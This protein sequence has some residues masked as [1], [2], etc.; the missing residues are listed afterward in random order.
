MIRFFRS[1]RRRLLTENRLSKY[2]L[3]AIGEMEAI[4]LEIDAEL[5][6]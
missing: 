1:L 2:L 3:H 4:I 5:K 6:K